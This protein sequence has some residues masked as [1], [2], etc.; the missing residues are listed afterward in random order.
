MLTCS[1]LYENFPFAHRA[2]QHDGHCR[3]IHGHNWSFAI[4]FAAEQRDENGFVVDFG[5]L[6]D[7]KAKFDE[8]FDHT[9]LLNRDDPKREQIQA[10][11]QMLEIDNVR[12]VVD[13][14]CEG[15]AMLVHRISEVFVR[16]KTNGRVRVT[17]V[18]VYEDSKNKATYEP[19][20]E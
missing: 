5:K 7:L 18:V 6:K 17:R 2:P 1:K 12:I 20:R 10:F 3:L 11:V 8:M 14:S 16:V 19:A 15:I 13:C 9:L 4:T